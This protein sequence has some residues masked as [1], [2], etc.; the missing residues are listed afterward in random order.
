MKIRYFVTAALIAT[1]ASYACSQTLVENPITKAMMGVYAQELEE[2]PE[3]YEIYFRRANEYYNLNQYLRALSDIDNALKYTPETETDLLFQEYTLRA[4]IYMMNDRKEDALLDLEKACQLD[5]TSYSTLFLKANTE[6]ELGKYTDAKTDYSKLLRYDQRMVEPLIGLARIAVKENNL[7]LANEYIDRAVS[8]ASADSDVYLRRADVR[9]L[10]GNNTGAVDDLII[11]ISIDKD[12]NRALSE[13][14]AMSNTD[15]NAVITGLTSAIQQA[16]SVGMFVYLRAVISMSHYRYTA[17]I[18]DFHQIIDENLYNYAGI[19]GSLAECY[20]GIGKYQEALTEINQALSMTADN[21]EYYI[22]RAQIRRAMG[23]Y[24]KALESAA[25]A[26]DKLPGSV[27]ALVVKGLCETSVE[28]YEEASEL[29]GEAIMD[30]PDNAYNY[31][32]R[33]NVMTQHLNQ[34]SAAR[35]L[36]RRVVDLDYDDLN[37]K[38]FKG[39]ALFLQGKDADAIAWM[40]NI[41]ANVKD[42]DG[43]INYY[44]ACFFSQ[45][46]NVERAFSCMENALE[47]GYADYTNWTKTDDCVVSVAK[48]RQDKRF[49]DLLSRYDYLFKD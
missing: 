15:Y 22:T 41:L 1:S 21:G 28:K 39:F 8:F 10:M 46:G 44:G 2:N 30:A 49:T 34:A 29:F 19:Y 42:V 13:L 37:V 23:D 27:K 33:A 36:Y 5:P 45:M 38:S 43:A 25:T 40:E 35:N 18:A 6:Y 26:V 20:Y 12:N 24:D 16:P 32:L 4:N 9:K 3:Y 7:G 47:N 14:V 31:L 48:I 11:A 17:A